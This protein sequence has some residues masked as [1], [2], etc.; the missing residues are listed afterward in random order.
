MKIYGIFGFPLRHT[1]SPAMQEA[2]FEKSGLDASYLSLELDPPSFKKLAAYFSK[3]LLAGFNITVPYKQTVIPYLDAVSRDAALIGAVNTVKRSG[4]KFNGHNTDWQGFVD[5]LKEARFN[6]AGKKAVV[7]GAG[8]AARACVYG[9]L[10]KGVREIVIFNRRPERAEKI[11]KDF[12]RIFPGMRAKGYSLKHDALK[13]ELKNADLLLNTTSLGLK[14]DDSLPARAE[15]IPAGKLLVYDLIYNPLETPF[16]KMAKRKG[17]RV[18]N[19]VSMLL[20]QGARAFEIWT[21]R[22]APVA[23]MRRVLLEKLG[24][25]S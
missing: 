24:P 23:L 17:K 14:N 11:K 13:T 12:K 16:L 1:L 9:L 2:A 3:C 19:G 25:K 21:G 18:L 5:A 22:K 4:K 8:G 7:L 6:P 10:K 20:Y 15:V